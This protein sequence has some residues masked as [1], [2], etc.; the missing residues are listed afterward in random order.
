MAAAIAGIAVLVSAAYLYVPSGDAGRQEIRLQL[1]P[2]PGMRFVSVPA[3]SPDG[4][5]IVFGAAPEAGGPAR[6]WLRPLSATATEIPGTTGAAFP[7][8]SADGRSV[9]FFAGE[10]LKRVSIAG[11]NPVVI[12]DAPAGRGG[13]WLDDESIVFAPTTTSPL[14]R[15]AAAGG[16]PTPL[17]ALTAD[18]AG[19]RFPQ[20]LP[21]NQLLYYAVNRI[22]EKNGVRLIAITDA[23]RELA[24]IPSWGAAEYVKGF[25]VFNG[26][27]EP[28]STYPLLA[29]RLSLP[30]GQLTGEPIEIGRARVSETLGRSVMATSANGVVATLGRGEGIGQF[31]WISRDGRLLESIGEPVAQ[32]GVELSPDRQQM[33]TFRSREI[34][35]LSLERP[36]PT[37]LLRGVYRH[38]IWSPDGRSLFLLSQVG[39]VNVFDLVTA[40]VASGDVQKLYAAGGIAKPVGSLP[41]GR[42]VWL[43][44]QSSIMTM[45]AGGKPAEFFRDRSRILEARV[46]PDGRWIA[47]ATDRSGRFEIE[48][49]SFA[50]PGQRHQVSTTGGGYPRWRADGRELYFV[51][52]DQHVMAA[53]F[54]PGEPPA[55]SIPAALFAVQLNAHPD[56]V[57]FAEYE[58]DVSADGSRFLVNRMIAPAETSLSVIVDWNPP[59]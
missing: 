56:R 35:T 28:D 40:P 4:R 53:R 42:L 32:L 21:G 6:L 38:P 26:A 3:I 15:V 19:H 47:Y 58:Y 50:Q 55:I 22:P 49:Q 20:R 57:S 59:R 37:R 8:W 41:D 14:M 36:V 25:L 16:A 10:K 46:S 27:P 34:W 45:T 11:G 9:A 54:T 51:S 17:T 2:P 39:G 12:C 13:L 33:V 52:A 29:Q 24:F 7:F 48:V 5:Q 30:R 43:D 18:E 44:M 23:L 1:P 31:A